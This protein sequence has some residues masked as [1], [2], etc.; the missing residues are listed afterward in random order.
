MKKKKMRK[1]AAK[2]GVKAKKMGV[3]AKKMN[4]T[5][6]IH[7]IQIHEGNAPCFRT[8]NNSCNRGDCCWRS[9]C[10]PAGRNEH[11]REF[12]LDLTDK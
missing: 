11:E 4:K 9:D 5:D 10:L 6:Q 7:A 12:I 2:L 1:K 3:K 8:G